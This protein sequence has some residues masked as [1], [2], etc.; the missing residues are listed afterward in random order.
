MIIQCLLCCQLGWWF[1][2][3]GQEEGWAPCSYLER[4]NGQEED[5]EE[6]VSG[7]GKSCVWL[8][9]A[10]Y[11]FYLMN[12]PSPYIALTPV[13]ASSVLLATM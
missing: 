3:T 4:V 1:V 12:E 2:C 9:V 8:T 10:P 7:S 13:V 5:E 11:E 6:D